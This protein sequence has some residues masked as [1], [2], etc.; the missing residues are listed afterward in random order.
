MKLYPSLAALAID[1][2]G[3]DAIT[4]IGISDKFRLINVIFSEELHEKAMTSEEAAT[5]LPAKWPSPALHPPIAPLLRREGPQATHVLTHTCL[6][7]RG[8]CNMATV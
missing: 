1:A 7:L 2:E 3:E 8:A 6:H 4:R 5:R